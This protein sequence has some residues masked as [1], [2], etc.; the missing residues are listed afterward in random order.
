M[1]DLNVLFL[2]GSKRVS[3]ANLLIDAGGKINKS[4]NI[5]SYELSKE[6]PIA[7]IASIIIGG[8]WTDNN[9][10]SDLTEVIDKFNIDMVIPFVDPATIIA[11]KLKDALKDNKPEVY[12]AISSVDTCTIFYDKLT[13]SNWFK[14]HDIPHP[15]L[16]PDN[17]PKIAKPIWG[18]SSKGIVFL[19]N[20]K[21][22][23]YYEDI[24][25]ND[26]YIIEKK[27]NGIEI[28]VDAYVSNNN[29]LI[30]Y[31]PRVREETLGGESTSTKTIDSAGIDKI[32]NKVVSSI[33]FNGP[34]TI[35]LI[36][37]ELTDDLY[38]I[39][40]NPRLG[41]GVICSIHADNNIPSY[42]LNDLYNLPLAPQQGYKKNIIMKRYF[43]EVIFDANNN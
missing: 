36:K 1:H 9:I 31:S 37:E 7:K 13:S 5:Y 39:E 3:F 12:I 4:I 40:I 20:N 41:G 11:A 27:I 22:V 21:D 25:D 18:S 43:E 24:I 34:I 14:Q 33:K 35:Q 26:E 6:C 17:F 28:T 23:K 29:Q 32:V 2:G 42:L 30:N 38:V 19:N 8:K 16:N 15:Q 10:L